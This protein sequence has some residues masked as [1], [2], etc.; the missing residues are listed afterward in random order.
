[1]ATV[2]QVGAA[3]RLA[4]RWGFMRNPRVLEALGRV[5]VLCFEDRHAHRGGA[6]NSGVSPMVKPTSPS[7][8]GPARRWDSSLWRELPDDGAQ[9]TSPAVA[10]STEM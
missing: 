5:D 1:M 4:R 8:H 9:G 2:A 10:V 6:F 3:R 7:H